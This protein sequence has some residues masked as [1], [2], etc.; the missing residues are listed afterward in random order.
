MITAGKKLATPQP[1]FA[2]LGGVQCT[3]EYLLRSSDRSTRP[4]RRRRHSAQIK[5]PFAA[6]HESAVGPKRPR[7]R[8]TAVSAFRGIATV[9]VAR[10][11][12]HCGQRGRPNARPALHTQ[13]PFKVSIKAITF[14]RTGFC[15]IERKPRT[16]AAPS[17]VPRNETIASS[18]SPLSCG[19]GCFFP[20]DGAPSKK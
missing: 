9:A 8:T 14:W 2:S 7:R 12:R 13:F 17:R 20:T 5:T 11:D 18:D 19:A 1:T 15:L 6:L 16:R 3:C 4:S 10:H